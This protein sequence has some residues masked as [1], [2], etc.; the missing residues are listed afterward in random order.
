MKGPSFCMHFFSF[1]HLGDL[2]MHVGS[3]S[4]FMHSFHGYDAL[5]RNKKTKRK[6][7]T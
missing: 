2:K 6:E 4:L 5:V 3:I 1:M 7:K